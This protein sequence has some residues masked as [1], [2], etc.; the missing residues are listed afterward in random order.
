MDQE[1]EKLEGA[2]KS[3]DGSIGNAAINT[4]ATH[5]HVGEI[6]QSIQTTKECVCAIISALMYLIHQKW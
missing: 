2:I 5:K 4:T 6:E 3:I 1:F